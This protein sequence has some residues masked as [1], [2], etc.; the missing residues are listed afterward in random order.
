M[1]SGAPS[2]LIVPTIDTVR[3]SKLLELLTKHKLAGLFVGPTGT[4]KS[5]YMKQTLAN[6]GVGG[7]LTI[8]VGFSAQTSANQTQD[9]VDG[10]LERRKK[11]F[12][13]P[14]FGQ[15]CVIFVDDLNMPKKEQY[16]A[17]PALELLRQFLDKGGWYDYADK[18]HPFRHI[19]DSSLLAAMG[20]PS[21]GRQHISPRVQRH[22][23]VISIASFDD[24]TMTRIFRCILQSYLSV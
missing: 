24:A 8:E 18:K 1:L 12:Y 11:D 2:E 21:A 16:G 15:Q 22:F 10:R 17:Q 9:I 6:L 19:I 13:G 14:H 20:S 3:Y 5:L 23:V 4:G 7:N